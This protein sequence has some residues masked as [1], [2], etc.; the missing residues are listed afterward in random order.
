M[1]ENSVVSSHDDA[2]TPP[3]APAKAQIIH[4]DTASK[5]LSLFGSEQKTAE[6]KSAAAHADSGP[7][8]R[9][10]DSSRGGSHASTVETHA[11]F[12]KAPAVERAP[13]VSTRNVLIAVLA[14]A[15]VAQAGF[16]VRER[17]WRSPV[18]VVPDSGTLSVTS[19]P[20]GAAVVIDGTAR[21][22]TPMEIALA[23][24]S[25]TI[26]VGTG[27]QARSQNVTI[28]PGNTFSLHQGLNATPAATFEPG[29]GGLQIATEPV[30]ARVSIDGVAH[31]VAPVT[32]T[33]LKVGDHV[34]TVRGS[35][36]DPV[37]RTVHVSE[38]NVTSLIVSMTTPGGFASGWLALSSSIPL[39]I[40]E[41]GTVIGT[42]ESPRILLPTGTHELELVNAEL[43]YR[44]T[45]TVQVAAGQTANVAMKLPMGAISINALPWAEVWV[46]GQ[47]AG[48]TPIGNLSVAIGRHELTFRHPELGEQRRSVTVGVNNPVRVSAD[49][50]KK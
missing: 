31:G 25:H 20:V 40:L 34:V 8:P 23:P 32:V 37:N 5:T 18:A 35:S 1:P 47:P 21:G 30:G 9:A 14:V 7:G 28:T 44:S 39:Q 29:T 38:A 6:P 45:R 48:E 33:N 17:F 42:T 36:G 10:D 15:V 2:S 12:A 24:G 13:L 41:R 11:R 26:E 46:D 19:D 43:G 50:R 3:R 16:I 22:N 4:L 49:M 27:A